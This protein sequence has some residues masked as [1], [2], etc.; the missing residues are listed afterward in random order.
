M[1]DGKTH[2]RITVIGAIAAA[3]LWWLLAPGPK[4]WTVGATLVGTTLISGLMFS[5]D[6][7]LDSSIYRRWGPFRFI[8]WPYQKV[9]RHRST[10]SHSILLGPVFRLIYFLLFAYLL[11]RI[12][13]WAAR[14]FVPFDRNSFTEQYSDTVLGLYALYPQHLIWAGVGFFFGAFLHVAADTIWSARKRRKGK[15]R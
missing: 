10:V 14:K 9:V 8:W 7:D 6:L 5:P 15:R 3:P 4:D 2:D 11:L 12:T 13:T 1:P